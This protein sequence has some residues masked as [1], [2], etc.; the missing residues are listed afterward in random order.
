[1]PSVRSVFLHLVVSEELFVG[2]LVHD[3]DLRVLRHV[4]VVEEAPF[5]I[6]RFRLTVW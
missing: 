4:V 5:T 1:M 6:L 3:A 2:T